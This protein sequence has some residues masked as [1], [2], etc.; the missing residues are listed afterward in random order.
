VSL[1]V[2]GEALVDLILSP[3]G[4]LRAVPGGGPFN[5]ARAA[6][7]LGAPVSFGGGVSDDAFG[8]TIAG[9]LADDQVAMA[10]P[11]RHGLPTTLALAEL[12]SGGAATYH[13]YVDGTAAPAVEVG[14]LVLG[15]GVRMLAVG[16]LGLVLEPVAAAVEALVEQLAD[17]VLVMVDPNC[18]PVIIRDEAAYRARL[19][20]ILR[21]ADVV[22]VS[23][24]DLA[25]LDPSS[26]SLDAARD[27]VR[28]GARLV[29][30]TDGADSVR[31]V[32]ADDEVVVPV[33]A[34]DVVDTVGA[35]DAF[36]GGFLAFWHM[37]GRG[38]D[39]LTD[40]DLVRATVERAIVVAGIT[41]TRPGADPPRLS[42]LPV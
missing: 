42:E 27:L 29:L 37:A 19:A 7:R 22:K 20:R 9:L 12:D 30:F 16:T 10:L 5:M 28:G 14:D 36:G 34:V 21:R 40:L 38:R 13:F 8:R 3:D 1:L 15:P 41:C 26:D 35:G 31:I 32:T 33:P 18:R 23:G 2:V 6:A 25:W 24:D 17:D 4:T 11:V 39:E